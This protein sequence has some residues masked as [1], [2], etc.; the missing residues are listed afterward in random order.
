MRHG[1]PPGGQIA[2]MA[3]AVVTTLLA[4]AAAVAAPG[5]GELYGEVYPGSGSEIIDGTAQSFERALIAAHLTHR[6]ST[7]TLVENTK[8]RFIASVVYGARE[9]SKPPNIEIGYANDG[10]LQAGVEGDFDIVLLSPRRQTLDKGTRRPSGDFKLTWEWEVTP[11]KSGTL[12]LELTINPL[13]ILVGSDRDDLRPINEP[14]PIEVKVHPNREAL[15]AVLAAAEKDLD[16]SLPSELTVGDQVDITATL[17]L[18]RQYDVVKRDITLDAA[19]GSVRTTIQPVPSLT[20]QQPLKRGWKLTAEEAG[21]VDL[22]F[23]VKAGTTA[24]DTDLMGER[25]NE[26]TVRA[27]ERPP[28]LWSRVQALVPWLGSFLGLILAVFGIRTAWKK[29]HGDGGDA[30]VS[31]VG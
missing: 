24:G 14:V 13:L 2:T 1:R 8:A 10:D 29:R 9:P 27:G 20:T 7:K 31:A 18:S 4:A 12:R 26:K 28:S 11:R 25:S 23:V 21:P 17:P 22:V 16:I 19:P 30:D 5:L 15:T 6:F 3:V